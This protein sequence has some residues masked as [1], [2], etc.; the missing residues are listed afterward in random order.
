MVGCATTAQ[1]PMPPEVLFKAQ[2]LK[3][4]LI[5]K[6]GPEEKWTLPQT[7]YFV[8][9]VR[10]II[11]DYTRTVTADEANQVAIWRSFQPQRVDVH[12][13]PY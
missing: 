12:V 8:A 4:A 10:S 13:W 2:T 3:M 7:D 5:E 9:G 11:N 6:W 1:K